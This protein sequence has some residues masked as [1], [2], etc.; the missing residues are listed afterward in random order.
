MEESNQLHRTAAIAANVLMIIALFMPSFSIMG[1]QT[2]SF[3]EITWMALQGKEGSFLLGFLLMMT[4]PVGNLLVLVA[5]KKNKL[6]SGAFAPIVAFLIFL[7]ILKHKLS[8]SFSFDRLIEYKAGFYFYFFSAIALIIIRLSWPTRTVQQNIAGT[9]ME[10]NNSSILSNIRTRLNSDQPMRF[11]PLDFMNSF[12]KNHFLQ[13]CG[14]TPVSAKI[15]RFGLVTGMATTCLAL[16]FESFFEIRGIIGLIF[17]IVV[18]VVMA[19]VFLLPVFKGSYATIDKVI[20]SLFVI[21][22]AMVCTILGAVFNSLVLI[23]VVLFL[24]LYAIR[25]YYAQKRRQ[26]NQ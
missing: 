12:E 14:D 6:D 26:S 24:L 21:I 15:A 7:Y 8:S 18:V 10:S 13:V 4:I 19:C 11:L 20:Y 23:Y 1:K 16:L 17:A 9:N 25:Q 22:T 5:N 3:W 2:V